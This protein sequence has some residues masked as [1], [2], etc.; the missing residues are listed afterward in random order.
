MKRTSRSA[1]PRPFFG[2]NER[3]CAAGDSLT[4]GGAYQ[5]FVQ[6]YYATRFPENR[7]AVFNCGISGNKVSHLLQRLKDDILVHR[8]TVV[9]ILLGGNDMSQKFPVEASDDFVRKEHDKSLGV[10]RDGMRDLL[11]RLQKKKVRIILITPGLYDAT[12]VHPDAPPVERG[13]LQALDKCAA[14]VRELAGEFGTTLVDWHQPLADWNAKFQKNDPGATLIGLDRVHAGES[15]NFVMAFEFLKALGAPREVACLALDAATGRPLDLLRAAI[16]NVIKRDRS[17]AFDFTE[18]SL[19]FPLP[20]S[21]RAVLNLIPFVER[22][23]EETLQVKH[24]PRGTYQ[25]R[26]DGL[27][28]RSFSAAQL[29]KGV[30]LAVETATPQY[31]Q[32]LAVADLV[33]RRFHIY[34]QHLRCIAENEWSFLREF[35]LKKMSIKMIK[36][37]LDQKIEKDKAQPWYDYCKLQADRYLESKLHEDTYR[38]E[39]AVLQEQIYR[40]N[41][42]LPHHL[43]ISR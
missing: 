34:R 2:A 36:K 43:E 21:C 10:F 20:E 6:L 42:P 13:F 7:L 23:N 1:S 18:R 4:I 19:P 28:I 31:R 24:L 16:T 12:L 22:F 35:N 14:V 9:S 40:V 41:Q 39:V 8:P 3:W 26:I 29:Q 38:A 15:G 5:Q 37:A 17:L 30:N 27:P 33:T 32:A 11:A 25:L